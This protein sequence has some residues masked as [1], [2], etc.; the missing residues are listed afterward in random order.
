MC[1]FKLLLSG[2]E[3][4]FDGSNRGSISKCKRHLMQ[5]YTMFAG[6]KFQAGKLHTC[7]SGTELYSQLVNVLWF[8]LL[9]FCSGPL[10]FTLFQTCRNYLLFSDLL[11]RNINVQVIH[12]ISYMYT[13]GVK[14]TYAW[15]SVNVRYI[16]GK[17]EY[18]KSVPND[19]NGGR[20]GCSLQLQHCSSE[21]TRS[22]YRQ[23]IPGNR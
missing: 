4:M 8:F 21:R 16:L 12:Q 22:V 6:Y 13:V 11:Q 7:E 9:K 2:N 15:A 20:G 5:F 19:Q 10:A 17:L 3:S 14:L 23:R 1:L 18:I